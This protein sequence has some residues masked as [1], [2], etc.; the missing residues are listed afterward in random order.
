MPKVQPPPPEFKLWHETMP[1]GEDK[2]AFSK[3]GARQL[4]RVEKLD[5]AKM[6][7]NQISAIRTHSWVSAFHR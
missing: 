4:A 2:V 6:H 1:P 3:Q 5:G 7:D